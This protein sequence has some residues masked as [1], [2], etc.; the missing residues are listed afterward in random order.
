M[1]QLNSAVAKELLGYFFLHDN[2]KLYLNEISRKLKL[3]KRN[4]A[5]KLNEFEKEGLFK[6]EEQANLSYYQL[7]KDFPLYEEYRR[8]VLK[9]VGIE[10]ELKRIFTE[11]REIKTAFIIGSYA[12]GKMDASSDID[13]LV[14]GNA[15]TINLQEKILDLQRK[16]SRE[17][18]LINMTE[19]EFKDR[20]KKNDPFIVQVLKDNK[21]KIV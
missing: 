14:I 13:V 10:A 3:D 19:K 9:T 21:I 16:S 5:K 11:N 1:I 2:A 7:N 17:I 20:Q 8:I 15:D 4:L 12:S 6:R 18:N